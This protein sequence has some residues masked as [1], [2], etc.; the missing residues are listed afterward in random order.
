M[1][2]GYIRERRGEDRDRRVGNR[3][4]R[5]VVGGGGEIF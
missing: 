4:E 5:G 3:G 2:Y 1:G